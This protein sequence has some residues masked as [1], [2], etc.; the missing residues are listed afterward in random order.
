MRRCWQQDPEERLSFNDIY[1]S[2]EN[3]LSNN[4]VKYGAWMLVSIKSYQTAYKSFKHKH[5]SQ[6]QMC[7]Q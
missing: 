2:L 1:N 4:E 5:T 6:V 3:M 7:D